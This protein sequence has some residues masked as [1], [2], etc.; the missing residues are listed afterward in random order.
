MR[1]KAKALG[2]PEA[3][4]AK[5]SKGEGCEGELVSEW[6]H[7]GAVRFAKTYLSDDEAVAKMG[8]PEVCRC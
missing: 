1:P 4:T 5:L 8:Y 7:T 6:T 2:Y 3:K